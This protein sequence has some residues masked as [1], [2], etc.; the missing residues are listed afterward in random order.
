MQG[1]LRCGSTCVRLGY[2]PFES[3][4]VG[5]VDHPLHKD[6]AHA[7]GEVALPALDVAGVDLVL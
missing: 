5:D 4:L 7:P 6:R 3:E 2:L 1:L